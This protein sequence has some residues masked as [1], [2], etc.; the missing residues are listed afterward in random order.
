M[1]DRGNPKW[2]SKYLVVYKKENGGWK[3]YRDIG[4]QEKFHLIRFISAR[5]N[6]RY[7][8]SSW[9]FAATTGK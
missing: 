4:L 8:L 9:F 6:L 5:T 2:K 7:H 3:L 1:D